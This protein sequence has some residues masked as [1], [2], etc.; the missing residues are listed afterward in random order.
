[1]ID[2]LPLFERYVFPVPSTDRVF[3]PYR[4]V[5][6]DV[7]RPDADAIRRANFAAYLGAYPRRPSTLL[8]AEA[9]GPWG[10]RFSG[11]PFTSEQQLL[12]PDFPIDGHPSSAGDAP[13]REY[14][15]TIFW[16]AVG[17][18]FPDV[19]VW[20]SFPFHPHKPGRPFTIR[21]PGIREI[22]AYA[23]LMTAL[24]DAVAPDRIIAVGRKGELALDRLG[25]AST[26][27]RHPSQGGATAFREGIADLLG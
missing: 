7:D 22:T 16:D 17:P 2:L 18:H 21:A 13:H 14:S 3:N 24:L 12:D 8:V 10:C 19:F 9:P 1:M 26:Y 15:G 25:V 11:V 27:V 5:N 6:P 23:D 4:D 20:N